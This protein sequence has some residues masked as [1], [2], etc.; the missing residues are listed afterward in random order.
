MHSPVL[1]SCPPQ[2]TLEFIIGGPVS[3]WS[4]LK[5]SFPSSHGRLN[6]LS[7]VHHSPAA[8]LASVS[9]CRPL[10]LHVLGCSPD[11]FPHITPA[12]STLTT[13]C[14]RPEGQTLHDIDVPLQQKCLS[15]AINEVCFQQLLNSAP[16]SRSRTLTLSC[17]LPH[18]GDWLNVVPSTTLGLH[19]QD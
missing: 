19:L 9:S 7:A 5:A 17:S 12:V 6:L 3:H 8:Y 10:M 15:H 2:G 16:M 18:T 4:W 11:Q 14:A 1:L 13:I